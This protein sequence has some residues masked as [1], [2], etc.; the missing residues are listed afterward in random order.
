MLQKHLLRKGWFCL[1]NGIHSYED[2]TINIP[3]ADFL[4]ILSLKWFARFSKFLNNF[5]I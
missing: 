3:V 1:F 5:D 4:S 2:N